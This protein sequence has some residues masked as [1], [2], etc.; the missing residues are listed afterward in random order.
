MDLHFALASGQRKLYAIR[1]RFGGARN[2]FFFSGG[3]I[4]A[5]CDGWNQA[6]ELVTW[7]SHLPGG[8]PDRWCRGRAAASPGACQCPLPSLSESQSHSGWRRAGPRQLAVEVKF[9]LSVCSTRIVTVNVTGP[10]PKTSGPVRRR[11]SRDLLAVPVQ[12]EA[13]E[14]SAS[15]LSN[16]SSSLPP[17][18]GP[19]R[20]R[21]GAGV[22]VRVC[23]TLRL[24]VT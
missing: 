1:R 24:N 18:P 8:G 13:L 12:H 6:C 5:T 15:D 9:S 2:L 17:Q 10:G 3:P 23:P 19:H 21:H 7:S 20:D 4:A 22:R 14:V 11:V 16:L